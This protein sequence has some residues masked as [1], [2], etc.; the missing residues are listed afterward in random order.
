MNDAN[1]LPPEDEAAFEE[2][3]NDLDALLDENLGAL[4]MAA[5]E[6]YASLAD[7][8][9][10]LGDQ[11]RTLYE[12]RDDYIRQY[13]GGMLVGAFGLGVLVAL[14]AGRR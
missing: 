6:A 14:L 13:P 4:Q 11:A 7:T 12:H 1:D 3:L 9:H 5:A 8:A 2:A 10:R